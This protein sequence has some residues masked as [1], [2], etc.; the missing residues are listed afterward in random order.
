MPIRKTSRGWFWGS[1]GPF[2]TRA[3]AVEV[4]Q[5]AHASGFKEKR[6]TVRKTRRK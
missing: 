6:K 3:K 5:A 4:A 2:K 1:K